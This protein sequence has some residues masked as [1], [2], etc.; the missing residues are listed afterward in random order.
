[1]RGGASFRSRGPPSLTMTTS[2][3]RRRRRG[4]R[5]IGEGSLRRWNRCWKGGSLKE[6]RQGSCRRRSIHRRRRPRSN[7]RAGR[8]LGDDLR[9]RIC[10]PE[11]RFGDGHHDRRSR[12]ESPR[13]G[14]EREEVVSRRM[15][16][17]WEFPE[18]VKIEKG[19]GQLMK[20]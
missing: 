11:V 3:L 4:R 1:M 15:L 6:R 19:K 13:G 2:K 12:L 9:K 7:Q 14:W 5:R 10:R 20:E 17:L 8:E 16:R 18:R